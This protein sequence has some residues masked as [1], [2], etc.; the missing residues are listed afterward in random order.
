MLAKLTTVL[1]ILIVSV[2][3]SFGLAILIGVWSF[4]SYW[5]SITQD[6]KDVFTPRIIKTE[7]KTIWEL[8]LERMRA[9][10]ANEKK[11]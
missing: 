7:Q 5:V 6:I 8:H 1:M 3:V 2:F 4:I 11:Q 9:K 10:N